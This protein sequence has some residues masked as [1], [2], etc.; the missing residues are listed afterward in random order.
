[1]LGSPLPQA[2]VCSSQLACSQ[3]QRQDALRDI[4]T[5]DC[6]KPQN[7]WDNQKM[8]VDAWKENGMGWG[9]KLIPGMQIPGQG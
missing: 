3:A 6:S 2:S 1:M 8:T 9:G 5:G 7:R 4:V